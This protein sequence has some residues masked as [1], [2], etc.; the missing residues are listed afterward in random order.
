MFPYSLTGLCYLVTIP[1]K[2]T[3][4]NK[5]SQLTFVN[6]IHYLKYGNGCI[7]GLQN[8]CCWLRAQQ[9]QSS[10]AAFWINVMLSPFNRTRPTKHTNRKIVNISY[11]EFKKGSV[12]Y[13]L[14]SL[15]W[16]SSEPP[17]H[18]PIQYSCT[19]RTPQCVPPCAC[20]HSHRAIL[21]LVTVFAGI[22]KS[23]SAKENR[24]L[25]LGKHR[26]VQKSSTTTPN[27]T[28]TTTWNRK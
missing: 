10:W 2:M 12:S 25:G 8:E 9:N 22:W 17:Q 18:R 7:W 14:A 24:R 13:Q 27:F 11:N 5:K 21:K 26:H 23:S 20:W 4:I 3:E 19:H 28:I 6:E 16:I 15:S 1:N